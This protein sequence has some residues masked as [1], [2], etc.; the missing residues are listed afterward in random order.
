MMIIIRGGS[1]DDRRS[2]GAIYIHYKEIYIH[3][4][5]LRIYLAWMERKWRKGIGRK[6]RLNENRK[7]F[8]SA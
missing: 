4:L 7:T 5:L 6:G 8:K 3:S 2:K 1:K